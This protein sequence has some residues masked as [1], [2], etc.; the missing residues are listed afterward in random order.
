MNKIQVAFLYVGLALLLWLIGIC[1]SLLTPERISL[2][3]EHLE[4]KHL[5]KTRVEL[6]NVTGLQERISI[7]SGRPFYFIDTNHGSYE[8]NERGFIENDGAEIVQRLGLVKRR[9]N[10]EN[11]RHVYCRPSAV[12]SGYYLRPLRRASS[13]E[14]DSVCFMDH[15]RCNP[16][17]PATNDPG[18][19]L[20]VASGGLFNVARFCANGKGSLKTV[21]QRLGC[22][23]VSN[24]DQFSD[25][26]VC[27]S[28]RP[29]LKLN[30]HKLVFTSPGIILL[31]KRIGG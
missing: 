30:S 4:I 15:D 2:T 1:A 7:R 21:C 22:L 9:V 23:Y 29:T 8:V 18:R 19:V 11:I 14:G 28:R 10:W 25:D 12:L 20:L 27:H 3:S 26:D 31:L 24:G 13:S 16:H 17:G 6:K 5:F